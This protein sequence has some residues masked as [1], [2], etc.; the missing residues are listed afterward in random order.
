MVGEDKF[1]K[2]YTNRIEKIEST[3]A[4]FTLYLV[5]KPNSF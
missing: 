5:L 3:I 4:A 2:S 1:R